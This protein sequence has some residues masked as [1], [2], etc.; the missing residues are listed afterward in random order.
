MTMIIYLI[1]LKNIGSLAQNISDIYKYLNFQYQL[2]VPKIS[3][4]PQSIT[5]LNKLWIND[6]QSPQI[7]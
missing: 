1:F 5:K 4:L 6:F 3:Q 7:H 2:K